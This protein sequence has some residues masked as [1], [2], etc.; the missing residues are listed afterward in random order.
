MK[1]KQIN[2]DKIGEKLARAAFT[3]GDGVKASR[4]VFLLENG[5]EYGGWAEGPLARHL[6][7]TLKKS[8]SS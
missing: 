3:A 1:A 2:Y 7:K 4:L 6:A 8:Q 5:K